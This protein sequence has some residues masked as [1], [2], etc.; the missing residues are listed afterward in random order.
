M[1]NDHVTGFQIVNLTSE[2]PMSALKVQYSFSLGTTGLTGQ[3]YIAVGISR[4]FGERV[5]IRG[6]VYL[7]RLTINTAQLSVHICSSHA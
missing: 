4:M 7:A 3:A 5:S 2:E 6:K 1:P